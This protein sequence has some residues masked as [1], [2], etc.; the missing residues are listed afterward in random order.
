MYLTK[1]N[2]KETVT[3]NMLRDAKSIYEMHRTIL[4]GFDEKPDTLLFRVETG[5]ILVL[6]SDE[7]NYDVDYFGDIQTKQYSMECKKG[8]V[9]SYRM[10]ANPTVRKM[11]TG[12][13]NPIRSEEDLV[14]W[15]TKK[16]NDNG[17]DIREVMVNVEDPK[18]S[19]KKKH[20]QTHHS[21]LFNGIG[22]VVDAD[23]FNDVL[24]RG[25]GRA[26]SYGFGMMSVKV[27]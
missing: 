1:I 12:K 16:A 5:Y 23:K 3:M 21:V 8:H 2:F 27:I 14:K 6:S 26:K 9:F 25:I 11:D 7:P 17:F 19:Y 10:R 15:I 13:N 20:K 18:I 24:I 22:S 4:K